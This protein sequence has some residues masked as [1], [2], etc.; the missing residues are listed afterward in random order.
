MGWEGTGKGKKGRGIC[1]KF[2]KGGVGN[3]GAGRTPLPL[4][5][6]SHPYHSI[7]YIWIWVQ[8]L[9]DELL[10]NQTMHE[11][12]QNKSFLVRVSKSS[13][14]FAV[15]D[16]YIHPCL[17]L[18]FQEFFPWNQL[19]LKSKWFSGCW[20]PICLLEAMPLQEKFGKKSKYE[21]SFRSLLKVYVTR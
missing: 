14:L 13:N 3:I 17:Q 16:R 2:E 11:A 19:F 7:E 21:E 12:W 5:I 8:T 1:T 18:K 20:K 10:Q 9:H 6:S 4:C 15:T